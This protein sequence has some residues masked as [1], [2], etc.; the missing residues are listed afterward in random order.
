MPRVPTYQ[1]QVN[2][3]ALPGAR[4]SANANAASF[5]GVQA[6]QMGRLGRS[7]QGVGQSIMDWANRPEV[8]AA[9]EREKRA[10]AMDKLNK[11]MSEIRTLNQDYYGRKGEAALKVLEDGTKAYGDVRRKY[12]AELED[13]KARAVFSQAYDGFMNRHLGRLSELQIKAT[14][15]Q[16][17]AVRDAWNL[18]AIEQGVMNWDDSDLHSQNLS[19]IEANTRRNNEGQSPDVMKR[20]VKEAAYNYT[21]QVV[22]SVAQNQGP[23][24]ALRKLDEF[25]EM[26]K[27]DP[28]VAGK[29]RDELKAKVEAKNL[30][31]RVHTL[32]QEALHSGKPLEEQ[33]SW[34]RDLAGDYG[35]DV[36]DAVESKVLRWN[37]QKEAVETQKNR[38]LTANL[39]KQ[40]YDRGEALTVE[41]MEA[42]VEDSGLPVAEQLTIMAPWRKVIDAR[43]DS[44]KREAL[45]QE[46]DQALLRFE[47]LFEQAIVDPQKAEAY[48]SID[49]NKLAPIIGRDAAEDI[50]KRQAQ[51]RTGNISEENNFF[52]QATKYFK[53]NTAAPVR[54]DYSDAVAFGDARKEQERQRLTFLAKAKDMVRDPEFQKLSPIDKQK[55]FNALFFTAVGTNT[56][57]KKTMLQ[58]EQEWMSE[59]GF[60]F[61][62]DIR[63]REGI[64][65]EV[66]L[67]PISG[68]PLLYKVKDPEQARNLFAEHNPTAYA[69]MDPRDF[70][71]ITSATVDIASG[72]AVVNVNVGTVA[73]YDLPWFFTG[74]ISVDR[75][76]QGA[77]NY[78]VLK[79]LHGDTT[80]PEFLANALNDGRAR[81]EVMLP[82]EEDARRNTI[83]AGDPLAGLV[84]KRYTVDEFMK[85][86]TIDEIKDVNPTR[87]RTPKHLAYVTVDDNTFVVSPKQL[88]FALKKVR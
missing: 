56:G 65:E 21:Q 18:E 72:R 22:M 52:A 49:E 76:K 84:R 79:T 30:K 48:L 36:A 2:P 7:V 11:A 45:K 63:T 33:L 15:V 8:R 87:A 64:S 19:G 58:V 54:S 69:E 80:D 39:S 38:E 9:K 88:K 23:D 35:S 85:D 66:M 25:T 1:Q 13:E 50:K 5:G 74:S 62:E 86:A 24:V 12:M 71:N 81:V 43:L 17:N 27:F 4:Y 34:A 55:S 41:E 70:D 61:P 42:A 6:E 53:A 82:S 31:G 77:V 51:L 73:K 20:L 75:P 44:A 28:R 78:E 3:Q 68:K 16:E 10:Q 26:G 57:A 83:M 32:A 47:D 29:L 46:K 60:E 59:G 14:A 37:K 67:T 40:F